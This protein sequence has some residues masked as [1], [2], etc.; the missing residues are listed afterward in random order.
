MRRVLIEVP[1]NFPD[2]LDEIVREIENLRKLVDLYDV[3]RRELMER[4]LRA[5]SLLR[6]LQKKLSEAAKEVDRENN[7]GIV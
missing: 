7:P 4:A 5:E 2:D 3:Q 6:M 1:D